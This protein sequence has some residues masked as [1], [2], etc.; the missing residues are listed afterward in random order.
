MLAGMN[1][2]KLSAL[3]LLVLLAACSPGVSTTDPPPDIDRDP[4]PRP[5]PDDVGDG[6]GPASVE[7][8][9]LDSNAPVFDAGKPCQ[10]AG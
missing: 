3:A 7:P 9:E 6:G 2:R 8:C 5:D 10:D 1:H 4:E